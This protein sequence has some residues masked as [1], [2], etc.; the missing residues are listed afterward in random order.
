M[1]VLQ[2]HI[3]LANLNP[4]KGSEQS[5]KRPVVVISGDTMNSTLPICIVCPITS[6]VKNYYSCVALK[7]NK[8]NGLEVDSEVITFQVRALSKDRLGKR[9]G[10]INENQL[11][12][13][14]NGLHKS[15]VL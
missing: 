13:I 12:D 3:Y 5:G 2:K 15:L 14:H 11:Q 7:A 4:V 9:I 6:K 10:K 8:L 1:K